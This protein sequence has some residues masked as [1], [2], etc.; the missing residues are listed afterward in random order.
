M[1][2]EFKS[3]PF[4]I[5]ADASGE[6][7]RI[8]G[9]AAGFNNL[10]ATGD[11]IAPGA[12]KDDLASF[13][14]EGFIGGL[15]HNWDDPIGKPESAEETAKGLIFSTDEIRDTPEGEKVLKLSR[16]TRPVI[17]FLS[18][19]YRA[20]KARYL[21]G[22]DEVKA[23]WAK[24]GYH[25]TTVDLERAQYGARLLTRIKLYEVSP[26]TIPANDQ[27]RIS[28]V[29]QA[30]SAGFAEHSRSVA[31]TLGESLEEVKRFVSRFE[32]RAEA[33]FKEGRELSATN[34]NAMKAVHDQHVA[35]CDE[36]VKMCEKM[37]TILERTKPKDKAS[38]KSDPEPTTV[39]VF[40]EADV[41]T[42]YARIMT[43]TNSALG[44]VASV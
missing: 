8:S 12:F 29:K 40:D 28:G 31:S 39:P 16:G 11:I 42:R 17:Q 44:D 15:N 30:V 2:H 18:I 13:L 38:G 34:W 7:R 1:K 5:K 23:Y 32:S 21:E 35:A 41:T 25:P 20:L 3:L 22:P 6:G 26:V 10:D 36:H 24:Q 4:E 19:G 9:L 43:A 37:G 27:A 33:R 14:S